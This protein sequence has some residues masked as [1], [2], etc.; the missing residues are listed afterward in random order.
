MEW[1]A[2]RK[3]NMEGIGLGELQSKDIFHDPT[4]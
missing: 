1:S 2:W 3:D 4:K